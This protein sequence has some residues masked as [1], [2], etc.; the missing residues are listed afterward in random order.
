VLL[1]LQLQE[2]AVPTRTQLPQQQQQQ[3]QQQHLQQGMLIPQTM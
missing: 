2:P 3:Q 1:L